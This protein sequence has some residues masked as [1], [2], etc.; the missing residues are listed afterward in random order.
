M[1]V[2]HLQHVPFEGL[3]RIAPTLLARGHRLTATHLYAGQPLPPLAACDWLIVMGGP[4]GVDDT[5]AYPWLAAEKRF[6]EAALDTGKRV[7]GICLGAQLIAQALGGEVTRNAWREVG[8]YDV[9]RATGVAATRFAAVLPER[10]A[11]FH[12]HGDTFSLPPGSTALGASEACVNQG[13]ILGERVVGLQFHLEM[14]AQGAAALVA[15]CAADLAP[16][17]FVQPA[18]ALLAES[19]RFARGHRI[20]D[21][22]LRA[23]DE[24]G[25]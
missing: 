7:L 25:Q 5:G 10:F 14:T 2:H 11:A 21:E 1:H 16:G 23:L 24:P 22:L 8:W 15:H 12:W 20:M 6:I 4:M 17:P 18:A 3:G 13:F 9:T 19:S